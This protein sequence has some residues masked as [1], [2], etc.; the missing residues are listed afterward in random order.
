[1]LG[2]S[3]PIK[4]VSCNAGNSRSGPIGFRVPRFRYQ[5][6]HLP[7]QIK[8]FAQRGENCLLLAPSV[9]APNENNWLINPAHPDYKRIVVR[10]VEPLS[11]DP[12]MFRKQRSHRRH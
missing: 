8:E 2:T 4:A 12:R 5:Y 11:Y 6:L 3:G 7:L 1:V 10:E 9:L